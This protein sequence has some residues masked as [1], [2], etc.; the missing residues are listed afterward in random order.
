MEKAEA[1]AKS[2]EISKGSWK[3]VETVTDK[4]GKTDPVIFHGVVFK[5]DN[6]CLLK[7]SAGGHSMNLYIDSLENGS[8][9]FGISCGINEEWFSS[10]NLNECIHFMKIWFTKQ[11]SNE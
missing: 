5:K 8:L 6:L 11:K 3:Y 2:F 1:I 4:N 10:T 9:D 7:F